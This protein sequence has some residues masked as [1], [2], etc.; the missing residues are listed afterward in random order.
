MTTT[1]YLGNLSPDTT[2]DDL[3]AVFGHFGAVLRSHVDTDRLTGLSR[4][5]GCVEMATGATRAAQVLYGIPLHG[6][7]L[8]VSAIPPA[9]P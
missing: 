8:R 5:R 9:G 7:P 4:G 2:E 6:R 3:R 1:L